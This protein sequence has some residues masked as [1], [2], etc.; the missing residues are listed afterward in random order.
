MAFALVERQFDHY[1]KIMSSSA[2]GGM[3]DGGGWGTNRAG[4]DGNSTRAT[5]GRVETFTVVSAHALR[6]SGANGSSPVKGGVTDPTRVDI[7]IASIYRSTRNHSNCRRTAPARMLAEM[8]QQSYFCQAVGVSQ[9]A[10][11]G[12][13]GIQQPADM[14]L[15]ESTASFCPE[16]DT[17]SSE[18]ASTSAST[19]C[20]GPAVSHSTVV[21]A[22]TFVS[23]PGSLMAFA[24]L[25]L[26]STT[27]STTLLRARMP[28]TATT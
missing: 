25:S 16:S 12:V 11:P 13:V 2:D 10:M 8:I 20:A 9:R 19:S 23:S 6:G 14:P 28:T 17:C 3:N 24:S 5:H 26:S 7:E 21:G 18:N 1:V 22:S 4:A 27:T 15:P